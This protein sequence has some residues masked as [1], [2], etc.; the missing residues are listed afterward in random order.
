MN[1]KKSAIIIGSGI[2]GLAA[3]TRLALQGFEV[4]VFEKNPYPGGKLS[5]FEKDGY[6]FDAGPSLFTQ[7][8]NIQELFEA[9]GEPMEDYF[10][11]KPVDVACKYFFE[12]GKTIHAYTNAEAFAAELHEQTGE[13]ENSV[14]DYLD[15]SKKL[16][17][18][19]GSVFLNHSLH[20]RSTWLNKRIFTALKAVKFSYLFQNLHQYNAQKFKTAEAGQIFNRFATYNGSNPYKAPAMLSLIPHLELNEGTFYPLGGMIS[21]TNALYQL[22]LKKGVKFS[23]NA[24]VQRIIHTENRAHG[25]VVND[26]NVYADVVVSNADIYFT[27]KNLLHHTQKANQVLKQERSSSALIFYWGINQSFA[28]LGLHNIFFSNN[29]KGEFNHIFNKKKLFD[30]PTVYINITSKEDADHAPAGKENWF[31]MINVPANSG[32]NWEQLIPQARQNIIQKLNRLLKT[33]IEPLIASETIL[34]PVLIEERTGSYMGSLY[35]TSSNSKM[36]AFFRA[37]NFTGYIK[38]LYCC[39][40]SVHPGGGIPLCL[41]S[42]GITAAI[43]EKDFKKQ[44]VHSH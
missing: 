2:A 16:Y 24:P 6:R 37:P 17:N 39:G 41:K 14:L 28:E 44:A 7:P 8:Q 3:A 32:Q 23:F 38:N 43:I 4:K 12:S 35:G 34:D 19:I 36:A 27:Y 30:D 20:K 25:V 42:A 5:M 33:D 40:G 13:P 29:Y 9:A 22:A 11:F 31:V 26:E 15:N 10:N 21:I 1:Y 18:N